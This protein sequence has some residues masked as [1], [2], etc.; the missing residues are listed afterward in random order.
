VPLRISEHGAWATLAFISL[1][2]KVT[3]PRN[4]YLLV[5]LVNCLTAFQMEA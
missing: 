3:L 4:A 5:G 1:I 2:L